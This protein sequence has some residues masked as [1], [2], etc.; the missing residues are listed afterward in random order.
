M[1]SAA[2]LLFSVHFLVQLN[3]IFYIFLRLVHLSSFFALPFV[4][5]GEPSV[6]LYSGS[7]SDSRV[8]VGLVSLYEFLV[9]SL[10]FVLRSSF[11]CPIFYANSSPFA[12]RIMEA[13]D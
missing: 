2:R 4:D 1:D 10:V 7:G 12:S 3:I 5:S 11:S 9:L 8:N 6:C 13:R